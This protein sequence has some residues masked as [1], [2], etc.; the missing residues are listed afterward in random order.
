MWNRM[1]EWPPQEAIPDDERFASQLAA[2]AT[3]STTAQAV[4][5]SKADMVKRGEVSPYDADA[6]DL[7]LSV[8][9]RPQTRS[10]RPSWLVN[11]G[12]YATFS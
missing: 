7:T 3:I 6:L 2:P 4:I 8:V 12:V 1:K 9:P 10:S 5:E 11:G